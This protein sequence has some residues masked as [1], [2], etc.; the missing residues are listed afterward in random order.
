M[1]EDHGLP[2]ERRDVPTPF[3]TDWRDY[4]DDI[5]VNNGEFLELE[6]VRGWVMV[7]YESHRRVVS[8]V[9]PDDSSREH[10][11]GMRFR[12]PGQS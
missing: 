6:T 3:G 8:L 10:E 11:D 9:F 1:T 7:R 4:V 2:L 5:P 12:W